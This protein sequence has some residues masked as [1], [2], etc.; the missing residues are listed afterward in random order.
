M[1]SVSQFPGGFAHGITIKGV[2]LA[3]THPG[4]VFWVGNSATLLEGE[5]TASNGN[6]GTFLAP[7]STIDFAVGQCAANRGDV[8]FV[9]PGHT[10]TVTAAAG[11]DL[12]V[13]GIALIG[14]GS[15]SNRPTINFTTATS[16]D[17]DVDAANITMVNFLFTGGIDA[18]AGPIDVNAADFK[19]IDCE[20][21]DVTGQ[22]TDVILA[23]AN[24]DRLLIDGYFHN[25]AAAAG[26][27]SAIALTGMDNPVIRN[28]K[29][30]GN[31]SVGAIDIRT[32]AAVDIEIYDGYIWTKNSADI[33]IIDT[34]T[35][36]TGKIGP[37]ICMMLADNAANITEA[38]TGATFQ[39]FGGGTG[40]A[41]G[42]SLLVANLVG[43]SAI[44]L[45][46]T[47]ATDA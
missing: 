2:P 41:S 28:F 1:P 22:A 15:G 9:R 8:I 17:M 21:R 39:Y 23:D 6:K 4:R 38:V 10:E 20:Y 26:G 25:G 40:A 42:G 47:E 19:L 33:A 12:D 32:T 46:K 7:F 35:G 30:I 44:K 34:V 5:K 36:S 3:L 29:L 24:A 18:L 13:A 45:N 31:F 14:L 27:A 37:N 16:A 11:L 43:E